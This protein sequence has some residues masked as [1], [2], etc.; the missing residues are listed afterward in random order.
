M[1][2]VFLR[3]VPYLLYGF[4]WVGLFAYGYYRG[5]ETMQNKYE[6]EIAKQRDEYNKTYI[7]LLDNVR[8]KE[9]ELQEKVNEIKG[10]ADKA[11]ENTRVNY[12]SI[13]DKL[14]NGKYAYNGLYNHAS[15]ATCT[16]KQVRK[17][18]ANTDGLKCYT[19]NELRTRVERSLAIT[20]RCDRL[21]I[22]YNELLEFVRISNG[23]TD[24]NK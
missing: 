18:T 23:T 4:A 15:T 7:E 21:A 3:V 16:D 2:S 6:I 13:I 5:S 24:N 14:H 11:I 12:E 8:A 10:K 19:E 1:A 9:Y 22:K 17:V 20:E